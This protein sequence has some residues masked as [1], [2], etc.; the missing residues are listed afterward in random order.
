MSPPLFEERHSRRAGHLSRTSSFQEEDFA[1]QDGETF[2][3]RGAA[4]PD[5]PPPYIIPPGTVPRFP[6]MLFTCCAPAMPFLPHHFFSPPGNRRLDP[7]LVSR[8]PFSEFFLFG[9]HRGFS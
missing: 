2:S 6:A 4:F 5:L 3:F 1:F 9:Q 8:L 7:S